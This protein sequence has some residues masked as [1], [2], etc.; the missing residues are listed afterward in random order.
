MLQAMFASPV[1]VLA[2]A[3]PMVLVVSAMACFWTAGTCSI[4]ARCFGLRR[5][6]GGYGAASACP[7]GAVGGYA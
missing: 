2:R 6:H 3:M 5:C 1:L 7:A 4:G